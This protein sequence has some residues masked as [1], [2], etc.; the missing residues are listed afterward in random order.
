M[1]PDVLDSRL[2]C[3]CTAE[4]IDHR[5]YRTGQDK[6]GQD[7]TREADFEIIGVHYFKIPG[8]G[9]EESPIKYLKLAP[10]LSYNRQILK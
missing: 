10:P 8:H 5:P 2:C 4:T 3:C 6:G 7:R 9:E 1:K